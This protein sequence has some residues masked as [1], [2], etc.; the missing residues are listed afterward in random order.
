MKV[1]VLNEQVSEYAFL[2]LKV[3]FIELF[4]TDLV[5]VTAEPARG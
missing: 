3:Q 2:G 4:D 1:R 5:A